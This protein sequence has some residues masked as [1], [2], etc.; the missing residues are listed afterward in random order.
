V[1][2]DLLAFASRYG[3]EGRNLIG[4]YSG[5]LGNN[6]ED[7][8]LEGPRGEPI[9]DFAYDDAWY[10]P[11]DGLG[12]SLVINDPTLDPAAWRDPE[13]WHA[14]EL[15]D[16]S[17]GVVEGWE[18]PQGGWQIPGDL[19]QDSNLDL[20]DAVRD[21]LFL[22]MD[23]PI[24]LPCGAEVEDGG[25]LTLLDLNGDGGFNLSDAVYLLNYLFKGGP[26]PVRGSHC[27]RIE[28]CPDVCR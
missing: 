3:L 21:L 25:N 20:S 23:T 5:K 18:P 14:S 26:G 16:G 7:I 11:T 2:D 19:N 6:G 22:F 13:S 9:L 28:G 17:P 8:L 24:T 15:I 10:P 27:Q 12:H 4:E 1:A